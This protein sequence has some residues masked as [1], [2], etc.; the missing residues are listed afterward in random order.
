MTYELTLERL[1]DAPPE[2]VQARKKEV[3]FEETVRQREA[4]RQIVE[5]TPNGHIIDA[6]Q[7]VAGVVADVDASHTGRYLKALLGKR[8]R[9]RKAG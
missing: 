6:T 9:T 5:A 4:Y 2:V 8:T 3:A 7:P 1:I